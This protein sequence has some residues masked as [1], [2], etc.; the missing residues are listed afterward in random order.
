MPHTPEAEVAV[1]GRIMSGGTKVA[2]Q[3]VGT[4]LEPTH[5]YAPAHRLI[6]EA[7]Y[8]AY[9]S[10]DPM[11][12]LTIGEL[13]AK[14]LAA[15]WDCDESDAVT[16]VRDMA[17][18]QTF[19][20]RVE[21]HA[22]LV[23]RDSDYRLLLGLAKSIEEAVAT[24]EQGP[25]EV[26]GI[27][28]QRAMRIATSSLITHDMKAFGDLG[29]EFVIEMAAI[30]EAR[31]KGIELGAYFDLSFV[32]QF[33]HGLQPTE[34]WFLAGDP[35]AGKT[36]VSVIAALNF[37]K[38]QLRQPEERRIGTLYLSLE[39]GEMP[40]KIRLAQTV[41][42]IDSAYMRDGS[43]SREN[44][45]EITRLWG[46]LK[47]L[48]IHFDFHSSMRA[49]QIRAVISEGIRRHNVGL[50][51][52][53]H[54][55][56]FRMDQRYEK[57][58]QEDEDK[59]LFLKE[60]L[61]KDLNVAVICLAHTTKFSEQN[62]NKRP[63]LSNLR[64]SGQIAATADFVSFMFRNWEHATD[65][66]KDEGYVKETDAEMIWVKNRFGLDATSNFYFEP[67]SMSVR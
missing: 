4:L 63:T 12:S 52:I 51:V 43:L 19:G 64:G 56:H 48:P 54:F 65:K 24:E 28:S 29:R 33:I 9:Y 67:K 62:H 7:I 30:M 26:A 22:T 1:I 2:G 59:V 50:V 8:S 27:V 5:F 17:D 53:D 14:K 35:G 20:G 37:A 36:A 66:E 11:D 15:L 23:K 46:D 41:S 31:K 39:M 18:R 44:L 47:D 45:A 3:V 13:Q 60:A 57:Q 42:G 34:L 6:Y 49:S 38:R 40:S 10:D 16:R 32:D 61:C 55:R 58:V 25:E 21:D